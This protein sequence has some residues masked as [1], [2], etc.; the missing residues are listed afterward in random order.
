MSVRRFSIL[1]F[2]RTQQ[3]L[4]DLSISNLICYGRKEKPN[5]SFNNV[6][7][8]VEEAELEGIRSKAIEKGAEIWL[9]SLKQFQPK[10]A[11][12]EWVPLVIAHTGPLKHHPVRVMYQRCSPSR[13]GAAFGE[14]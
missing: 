3:H 10:V 11:E 13:T 4:V 12:T 9:S 5:S 6:E 1:P 14:V 8:E 7:V 2:S